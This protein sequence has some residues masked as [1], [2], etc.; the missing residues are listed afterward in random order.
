MGKELAVTCMYGDNEMSKFLIDADAPINAEACSN[1]SYHMVMPP[2]TQR[3]I[4][5][6]YN[7]PL[8]VQ[9]LSAFMWA[10]FNGQVD[11][12]RHF[13]NRGVHVDERFKDNKMHSRDER[14]TAFTW[15]VQASQ[16]DVIKLL[17]A[18]GANANQKLDKNGMTALMVAT[19]TNQIE[20]VK[21]LT[22]AGVN[23]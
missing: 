9:S 21:A 22:D 23:L 16:V 20:I 7:Q 13:I 5:N 11:V 6:P 2:Y 14:N 1:R 15:A 3:Y 8:V 10:A 12:V 18:S 4:Q 17:I 19:I